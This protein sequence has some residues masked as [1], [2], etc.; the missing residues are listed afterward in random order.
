MRRWIPWCLV[1][2]LAPCAAAQDAPPTPPV[3]PAP[4]TSPRRPPEVVAAEAVLAAVAAKDATALQRLAAADEPDPW[5]VAETLLLD[6]H[7]DEARAFAVAAPRL[8]VDALP[9][10]V[11]ARR[12]STDDAARR[13]RLAAANL[14]LGAQRVD[15]ARRLFEPPE[16][17]PLKDVLAVRLA[18]GRG[19]ALGRHGDSAGALPEFLAAAE[20][21]EALGWVARA[22]SALD[23]A[24]AAAADARLANESV[25]ARRRLA[26]LAER[27]GDGTTAATARFYAAGTL[28]E[29]GALGDALGL[30]RRA[31]AGFA[32][33]G[34]TRETAAATQCVGEA[35]TAL[36]DPKAALV[37]LEKAL[38]TFVALGDREQAVGARSAI[39]RA[40]GIRGEHAVALEQWTQLRAELLSMGDRVAAARALGEITGHHRDQ[41]DYE[42]AER[43][44]RTTLAE[45]TEFS[46][47]DDV[48]SARGILAGVLY[49]RGRY[50]EALDELSKAIPVLEA[51]PGP[52]PLAS[53]LTTSALVHRA[54]GDLDVAVEQ[55]RRALAIQDRA[56]NQSDAAITR[57]NLAGALAARG[58][59]ARALTVLE[60][61]L[62]VHERTGNRSAAAA[63]RVNM[64]AIRSTLGELERARVL[65]DGARE[66]FEALGDRDG[67]AITWT[68]VGAIDHAEGDFASARACFQRALEAFAAAGTRAGVPNARLN[69]GIVTRDLEGP[70]AALPLLEQARREAAELRDAR[71]ES[72]ALRELGVTLAALGDTSKATAALEAALEGFERRGE[73]REEANALGL[74]ARARAQA[75]DPAGAVAL[76]RRAVE[77]VAESARGLGAE[78]GAFARRPLAFLYDVGAKAA[79]TKGDADAFAF[80]V[81]SGR[82]GALVEGLASRDALWGAAVPAELR[83]A[84]GRARADEAAARRALDAAPDLATA[85]ARRAALDAARERVS[86]VIARIQR[87]AK[88]GAD[89]VTGAV[90]SLDEVRAALAQDEALVV[91][92]LPTDEARALVVTHDAARIVALGPTAAVT[93]AAEAFVP[94][95]PEADPT[96]AGAALARLVVAPLALPATA[97]HVVVSPAGALALVP[98]AALLRDVTVSYVPSGTV[99]TRLADERALRGEGVLALGDPA[100]PTATGPTGVRGS[101][102]ARLPATRDEA[103]ALGTRVLLGEDATE[104]GLRA[105]VATR[106]RWRAVHLACHGLVD[107]ER[108]AFS[109]LALT[110]A[111]ADD[112]FL[113][114]LEVSRLRVPADL[115]VLSACETGKGRVVEGEGLVGFTRV[116]MFAGTPRV[117]CSLWKVDD[118]A[119]AALMQKLYDLWNPRTG[120]QGMGTAEALRAAQEHVRSQE[121]WKHPYYWAAWV[122]WGLPS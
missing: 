62:A 85:R 92:D 16:P 52:L 11:A 8:D 47:P 58:D 102:L 35:M 119:T 79:A 24:G 31:A 29:T 80:F 103:K 100:Y 48:A 22:M 21:A 73:R 59:P 112:G 39:A 20:A 9:A 18:M 106:P 46:T 53:M 55:F 2:A 23:Y 97:R 14:A 32:S 56:N 121:K 98:F 88:A 115:V 3:A 13:E 81:E 122:L 15:D 17:R 120:S 4:P 60:E 108:P 76:A 90:A 101:R 68:N 51:S 65:L 110:P 99:L 104:E 67:V 12:P 49:L 87:E 69:A 77:R 28:L 44:A 117:I 54:L 109:S 64:A 66:D 72:S 50:P 113:G 61:A 114:A 63:V 91:Y 25:A 78:E 84:E 86:A 43:T 1:V 82:A 30:Y 75:G 83:A 37:E 74:L 41:G 36:G 94:S 26:D 40:H 95:E 70:A 71:A 118:A 42:Q 57:S 105:A 38:A 107:P 10:Y 45:V 7:A 27:R 5:T 116:F 93:A 89:L 96:E 6:G 34:L 19:I 111:G 33:V